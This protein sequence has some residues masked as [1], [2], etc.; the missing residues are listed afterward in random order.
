MYSAN[1]SFKDLIWNDKASVP[2]VLLMAVNCGRYQKIHDRN[3]NESS[4]EVKQPTRLMY[5]TSLRSVLDFRWMLIV[6]CSRRLNSIYNNNFEMYSKNDHPI[7]IGGKYC[8]RL[9]QLHSMLVVKKNR[10]NNKK[11]SNRKY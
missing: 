2:V 4:L 9:G 8:C 1:L 6:D 11:N 3:D 7:I 10:C 5:M